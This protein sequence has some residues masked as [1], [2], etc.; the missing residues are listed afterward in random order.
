MAQITDDRGTPL[1]P[2]RYA[3]TLTYD[4]SGNL[5]TDTFTDGTYTWTQTYTWT[6]GN[7]TSISAWVR[8]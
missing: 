5:L 8:S 6:A 2:E 7:L 3:H 4:G 1:Y